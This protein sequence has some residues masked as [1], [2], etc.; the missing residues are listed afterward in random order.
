MSKLM[1]DL[2]SSSHGASAKAIAEGLAKTERKSPGIQ[3]IIPA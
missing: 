3:P 2:A 1:T